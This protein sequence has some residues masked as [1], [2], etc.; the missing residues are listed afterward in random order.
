M[1]IIRL[2]PH[3]AIAHVATIC[4]LHM[5]IPS[6]TI[7][8]VAIPLVTIPRVTRQ[9]TRDVYVPRHKKTWSTQTHNGII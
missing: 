1:L 5:A 8:R 3:V 4:V 2:C 7:P 6:V 9:I